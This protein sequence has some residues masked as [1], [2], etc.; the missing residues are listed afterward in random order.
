MCLVIDKH[1]ERLDIAMHDALSMQII[2]S[3]NNNHP[4]SSSFFMY[5]LMSFSP[6]V[7]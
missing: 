3:L 1:V 4:T 2:E 7:G 5:I 6:K